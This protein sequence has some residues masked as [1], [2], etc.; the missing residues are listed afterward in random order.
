MEPE[1]TPVDAWLDL[2][3]QARAIADRIQ[4]PHAKRDMMEVVARYE[5][6]AMRAA[7][8]LARKKLT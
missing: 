7:E 3:K 4:D 6:L 2:A 1:T 5:R 8:A